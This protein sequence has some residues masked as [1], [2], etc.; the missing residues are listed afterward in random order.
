VDPVPDPLLLRKFGSAGNRTRDLCYQ[1]ETL[2]T[3]PQ[4]R[5]LNGDRFTLLYADDIR[6]LQETH[7]RVSTACYGD[8]FSFLY[9]DD[10]RTSQETHRYMDLYGMLR[11]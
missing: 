2:T 11:G 1:P 7:L 10:V 8:S 4:R 6:T 5:S 3:R 9:I